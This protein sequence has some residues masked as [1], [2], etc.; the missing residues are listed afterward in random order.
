MFAFYLFHC[1]LKE[2]D[3]IKRN[4]NCKKK[5]NVYVGNKYYVDLPKIRV[6]RTRTTK[7]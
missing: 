6:G 3:H 2:K 1:K 4:A 7:N 5:R